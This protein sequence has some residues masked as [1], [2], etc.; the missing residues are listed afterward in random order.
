MEALKAIV[1]SNTFIWTLLCLFGFLSLSLI[2]KLQRYYT[3]VRQASICT[4]ENQ[5]IFVAITNF[6]GAIAGGRCLFSLFEHAKCPSRIRVGIYEAS[7]MPRAVAVSYYESLQKRFSI[8]DNVFSNSIKSIAAST[9]SGGPYHARQSLFEHAYL[10]EDFILTIHDGVEMLQNWD[11]DLLKTHTNFS[12][13]LQN[14][15]I[16][17]PPAPIE[18]ISSITFRL[19]GV[20]SQ[21]NPEARY[22]IVGGFSESGLPLHASK[23]FLGGS[24]PEGMKSLL[25]LSACSFA[26]CSFFVDSKVTVLEHAAI[27]ESLRLEKK[28]VRLCHAIPKRT[29]PNLFQEDTLVTCDGMACGWTFIC[30]PKCVS[31]LYYDPDYSVIST[32][33]G[34][35]L[36]EIHT[37]SKQVRDILHKELGP[38]L[39]EL[40]LFKKATSKAFS[41]VVDINNSIEIE[42]KHGVKTL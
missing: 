1:E 41:G 22:P 32:R 34:I 26:P 9:K 40:G 20:S 28:E 23:P 27:D 3:S 13:S 18:T 15:V 8:S 11:V 4:N 38:Y 30:A 17:A 24:N 37:T 25:W 42:N 6:S 10:G 36:E 21:E 7:Y 39:Q 14:T 35:L 12:T 2:D 33:S 16:I 31:K 29:L 5:T 19:F